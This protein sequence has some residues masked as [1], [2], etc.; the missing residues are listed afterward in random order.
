[1]PQVQQCALRCAVSEQDSVISSIPIESH[2]VKPPSLTPVTTQHDMMP[3]LPYDG[4]PR[5]CYYLLLLPA[6]TLPQVSW[7]P[8]VHLPPPLPPTPQLPLHAAEA[9]LLHGLGVSAAP[10]AAG[11]S[12]APRSARHVWGQVTRGQVTGAGHAAAAG[13]TAATGTAAGTAAG[14]RTRIACS[15]RRTGTRGWLECG[16]AAA[17]AA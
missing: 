3:L 12:A 4:R 7:G 5:C 9:V 14:R 16:L 10:P 6:A 13:D 11:C 8:S 2:G 1:M 17:V 15:S